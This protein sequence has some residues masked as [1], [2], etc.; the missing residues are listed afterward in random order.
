[1]N[2]RE[3]LMA[4]TG[5]DP[6]GFYMHNIRREEERIRE[7]VDRIVSEACPAGMAKLLEQM[8]NCVQVLD[9]ETDLIVSEL[10]DDVW[11]L[12]NLNHLLVQLHS[13]KRNILAYEK[14]I[15]L[16]GQRMNV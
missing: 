11:R 8:I 4:M 6:I 13:S 14:E 10:L 9:E 2:D 16:L 5:G 15:A 3:L 1:M 7:L 12:A